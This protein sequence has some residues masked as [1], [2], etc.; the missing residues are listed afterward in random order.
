M[1]TLKAE[2]LI[3]TGSCLMDCNNTSN[4]I[5]K[6]KELISYLMEKEGFKLSSHNQNK[7][8]DSS[9][10]I[11]FK[12]DLNDKIKSHKDRLFSKLKY[13]LS[14]TNEKDIFLDR[15]E[16]VL[17]ELRID[18]PFN[19]LFL[20]KKDK[21]SSKNLIIEIESEPLLF[22]IKRGTLKPLID[23]TKYSYIK[24]QN[25]SFLKQIIHSLGGTI[26]KDIKVNE[27]PKKE[28]ILDT[29]VTNRLKKK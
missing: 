6:V 4:D 18:L 22:K 23:E 20:M 1:I 17:E 2:N 10:S 13:R 29:K 8:I 19:I 15:Y 21:D 14:S 7:S 26:I 3:F 25:I 9:M 16:N 28:Y 24:S 27:E 5:I 12:M 11:K